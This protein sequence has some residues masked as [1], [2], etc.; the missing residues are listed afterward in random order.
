M[1]HKPPRD[2]VAG[3]GRVVPGSA[4]F[5]VLSR[6]GTGR[7]ELNGLGGAQLDDARALGIQ[8]SSAECRAGEMGPDHEILIKERIGVR[9]LDCLDCFGSPADGHKMVTRK[10]EDMAR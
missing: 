9:A 7:A 2:W 8:P 3:R 5:A 6:A 10:Q 1:P 4:G